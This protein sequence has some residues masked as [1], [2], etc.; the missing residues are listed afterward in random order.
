[1]FFSLIVFILNLKVGLVKKDAI[2]KH[3][4]ARNEH[5]NTAGKKLMI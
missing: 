3:N 1:M 4:R 5:I 2:P